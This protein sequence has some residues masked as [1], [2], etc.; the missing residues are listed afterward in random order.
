MQADAEWSGEP[1]DTFSVPVG[2]VTNEDIMR[3]RRWECATHGHDLEVLTMLGTNDPKSVI[4]GRCGESWA[5][6]SETENE[7]G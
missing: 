2:A 4:C 1:S 6:E 7:N 3:V 5:V